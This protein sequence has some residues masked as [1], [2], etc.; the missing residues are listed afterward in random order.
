MRDVRITDGG[1]GLHGGR[2]KK[3]DGMF[4][5]RLQ[6]FRHQRTAG[7]G[8]AR[9]IGFMAKWITAEKVKAGLRHAA[10]IINSMLER[11]EGPITQ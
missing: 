3:V 6:S 7:H 4:R 2:G 8:A 10:L 9:F 5:E 11:R 1:R